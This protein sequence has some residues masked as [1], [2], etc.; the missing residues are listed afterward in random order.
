[1]FVFEGKAVLFFEN[2]DVKL[3][4]YE[5]ITTPLRKSPRGLGVPPGSNRGVFNISLGSLGNP[6]NV[7]LPTI[8]SIDGSAGSEFGCRASPHFGERRLM[9]C[10]HRQ[11][12]FALVC[13]F[14]LC[15]SFE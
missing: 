6:P 11:S 10:S 9:T 8:P 5:L 3:L 4:G 12:R 13:T 7:F 1:M 2:D 15:T 14:C